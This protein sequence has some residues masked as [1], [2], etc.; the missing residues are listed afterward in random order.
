MHLPNVLLGEDRVEVVLIET[1]PIHFFLIID[2]FFRAIFMTCSVHLMKDI[3]LRRRVLIVFLPADAPSF[4]SEGLS[5]R[6]RNDNSR[7]LLLGVTHDC[8]VVV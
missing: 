1:L 5:D 4:P 6:L 8:E 3:V 7:L 2:N